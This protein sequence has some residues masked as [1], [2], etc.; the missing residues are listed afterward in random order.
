MCPLS[1]RHIVAIGYSQGIRL[2]FPHSSL[3]GGH[4]LLKNHTITNTKTHNE[5]PHAGN[6]SK[7]L[8]LES[9]PSTCPR[10]EGFI[11]PEDLF[12]VQG[13]CEPLWVTAIRCTNCGFIGYPHLKVDRQRGPKRK[14]RRYVVQRIYPLRSGS[15]DR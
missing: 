13:S 2:Q 10:C 11:V 9:L 14:A 4:D 8:P 15:I 5:I 7:K 1:R 12:D 3:S 6:G